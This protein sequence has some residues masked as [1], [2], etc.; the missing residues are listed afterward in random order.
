M[1]GSRNGEVCVA[2]AEGEWESRRSEVREGA[3]KGHPSATF[4]SVLC[5]SKQIL[6][7]HMFNHMYDR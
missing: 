1:L 7:M 5:M 4:K 6:G 3:T 2:R